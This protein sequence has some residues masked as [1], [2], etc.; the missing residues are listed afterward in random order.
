MT[1]LL[2]NKKAKFDYEILENFNA[3]MEL[4][5]WEVK[6]L[7]KKM[8]SLAGSHAIIRGGEIF[9]VGLDISPYQAKNLPSDYEEQRTIRLLLKKKELAYLEGKLNNRG[10]T[11]VPIKLYSVNS[12]VKIEIGL[13]KGKKKFDKRENIKKRE[14]KVKI[15]RL[16]REK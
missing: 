8:A 10:L 1:T 7:K 13:A 5:G 3:G 15:G 16:M 14:A 9:L 2:E 12:K 6:S 4:K 11:I